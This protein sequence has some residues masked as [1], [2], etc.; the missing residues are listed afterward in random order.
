[1]SEKEADSTSLVIKDK[2]LKESKLNIQIYNLETETEQKNLKIDQATDSIGIKLELL[3]PDR[4][5][6]NSYNFISKFEFNDFKFKNIPIT[7]YTIDRT[8]YKEQNLISVILKNG[9]LFPEKRGLLY[10]EPIEIEID[11]SIPTNKKD[12]LGS[13]IYK[14]ATFRIKS[15]LKEIKY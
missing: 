6:V 11:A 2:V 10:I 7:N 9:V 5:S 13:S 12:F 1:M 4:I 8:T 15:E 14:K 3:F